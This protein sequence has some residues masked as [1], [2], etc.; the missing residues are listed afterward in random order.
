MRKFLI[1]IV[2]A[3]VALGPMLTAKGAVT[4]YCLGEEATLLEPMEPTR[5]EGRQGE[6]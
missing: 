6:T 1:G 3:T 4:R 5:S 2:M